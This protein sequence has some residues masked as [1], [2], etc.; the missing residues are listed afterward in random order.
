MAKQHSKEVKSKI[1]NSQIGNTNAVKWTYEK[2]EELFLKALELSKSREYDFIGE[3]AKELDSYKH[4]FTYLIEEHKD[5]KPIYDKIVCNCESNCFYNTKKGKINVA[6]GIVNL[7]SNHKWTDRSETIN[8]NTNNHNLN[9]VSTEALL[10]I[11]QL[12]N[13]NN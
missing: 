1:A 7:K 6:V 11:E 2:A 12:L 4:V 10:K 8:T 5:L 13:G 3:I 9:N